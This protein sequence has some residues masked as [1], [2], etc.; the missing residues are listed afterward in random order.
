MVEAAL[1]ATTD[2]DWSPLGLRFSDLSARRNL[3]RASIWASPA[4][5][6]ALALWVGGEPG[7]ACSEV[8]PAL[9]EATEV[10]G[11][12]Q[13][14]TACTLLAAAACADVCGDANAELWH[15]RAGYAFRAGG[16]LGPVADAL[17]YKPSLRDLRTLDFG[18]EENAL[19]VT[20]AVDS[21]SVSVT[22][23]NTEGMDVQ[24]SECALRVGSETIWLPV[25]VD[26]DTAR[27]R[28]K[29]GRLIYKA[30]RI[31]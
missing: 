28:R 14:A 18:L 11:P 20:L 6:Y 29:Q 21:L 7:K 5:A 8:W 30:S 13:C 15:K 26:P 19:P 3:F 25:L 9:V 10:V 12:G 17:L 2:A 16:A 1:A 23:P 24:A 27:V 4:L 31:A 22:V